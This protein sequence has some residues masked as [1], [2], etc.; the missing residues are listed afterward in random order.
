MLI[1]A[2]PVFTPAGEQP[3]LRGGAMP[4]TDQSPAKKPVFA[5]QFGKPFDS[6]QRLIRVD[7]EQPHPA[8]RPSVMLS[9]GAEGRTAI[10]GLT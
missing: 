10:A 7:S 3:L 8:P 2:L 5:G 4:V 9:C 1:S 6:F